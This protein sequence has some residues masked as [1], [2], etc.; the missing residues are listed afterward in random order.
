MDRDRV[1]ETILQSSRKWYVY[2]IWRSDG[3]APIPFYV[4]KGRGY[5]V[6]HHELPSKGGRNLH[7]Q[8]IID[9]HRARGLPLGYTL[10]FYASERSAFC[11]ECRLIARLGRRGIGTGV[12]ANL[13][14]GGEGTAGHIGLRG[15]ANPRARAVMADGERFAYVGAAAAKHGVDTTLILFRIRNGWPGY[16]YEDEGQRPPKRGITRR[17]RKEVSVLGR[18]YP[19]LSEAARATGLRL[20]LIAARIARG[21]A[22]YF[23]VAEGPRPRRE[24]GVRVDNVAVVVRGQDY[25]SLA[26]AAVETGETVAKISKRCSSS[27]FPDYRFQDP[28]KG[29]DQKTKPPV[30]AVA[31][32]VEGRDFASLGEAGRFH[33]LTEGGVTYRCRSDAFP[34]W[35]F[36]DAARDAERRFE[37]RFSSSPKIVRAEGVEYPS[38]SAAARALGIDINTFKRRCASASFPGYAS[39]D[40]KLRKRLPRDGR[41]GL[42]K[43]EID[44]IAHRSVSAAA[45]NRGLQRTEV[46]RRCADPAWPTWRLGV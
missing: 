14:D 19:S 2:A 15:D 45:R 6:M 34:H 31:V 41:A 18:V 13:T 39:S 37:P 29:K 10:S 20:S 22:G 25:R 3:A 33:G 16:Y 1:W 9:L 40:P 12:L 21:W 38:Q 46:R 43:V 26:I 30:E 44:G 8:R 7:K 27:N 4:G 32:V 5:R 23:Y 11:A 17:Y 24:K 36:A 35:R 28:N 42:L